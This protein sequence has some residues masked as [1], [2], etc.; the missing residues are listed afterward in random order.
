MSYSQ[1]SGG[2]V[3]PCDDRLLQRDDLVRTEVRVEVGLQFGE[4]H[5]RAV[6]ASAGELT[7]GFR[8]GRERDC[9]VEGETEGLVGLLR[10][11]V[12]E[13]V[14]HDVVPDGEEGAARRV[15]RGVLAVGARNASRERS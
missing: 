9:V 6:R 10:T 7:A 13:E 14:I 3:V 5:D 12:V 11:L 4:E 8:R 15:R 2:D 1:V